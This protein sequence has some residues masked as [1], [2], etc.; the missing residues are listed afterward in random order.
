MTLRTPLT[1]DAVLP[2]GRVVHVRVGVADDSYIPKRELNT[3]TLELFDDVEH[4]AAVATVL[5]VDEDSAGAGCCAEVDRR[6]SSPARSR[7]RPAP[8]SRSPTVRL[9]LDERGHSTPTTAPSSSSSSTNE[10]PKTVENFTKLARDGFYDGVIFHRVIPD[11]MI[12]G[13]DPTGTGSR[14]PGLHVR[15]RVQRPQGRARRAR[16]GER[17]PE[18]E[19]QRSSSSSPPRRRR[20]STASTRCS[21]ASRTAWTSSTRSPRSTPTAATSR[22]RTS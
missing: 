17:R 15:G 1:G 8:S 22:G 7:R 12:Q 19:R 3:V 13:G 9:R 21:A 16:D 11:F 5:D 4:L 18:H 10:A 20:G 2:D 6:A 14:R